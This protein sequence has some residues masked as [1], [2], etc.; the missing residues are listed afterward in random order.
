MSE[1]QY[2]YTIS[3]ET[4]DPDF[5]SYNTEIFIPHEMK[6]LDLY[7]TYELIRA[8]SAILSNYIEKEIIGATDVRIKGTPTKGDDAILTYALATAKHHDATSKRK[9]RGRKR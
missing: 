1:K 4:D 5:S 2:K 7:R 3:I 8:F 6:E 9:K